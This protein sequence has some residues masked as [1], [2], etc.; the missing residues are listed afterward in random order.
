VR[1]DVE[2]LADEAREEFRPQVDQVEASLDAV[3][4]ALDA[5]GADPSAETFAAAASAVGSLVQDAEAL[6]DEVGTT[7]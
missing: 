7:C 5:A 6:L 2:Q 4:D 3:E 1:D